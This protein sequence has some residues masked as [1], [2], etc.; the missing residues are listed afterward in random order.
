MQRLLL[1]K[2]D[3]FGIK[4]WAEFATEVGISDTAQFGD[5]IKGREGEDVIAKGVERGERLGVRG[6]PTF[7]VNGWHLY[8]PP[9]PEELNR[10]VNAILANEDPFPGGLKKG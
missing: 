1:A 3:S 2:Q 8:H 9:S 10:I 4:P 5:C 6:T 7:V